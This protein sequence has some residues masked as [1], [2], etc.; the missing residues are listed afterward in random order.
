VPGDWQRIRCGTRAGQQRRV[1]GTCIPLITGIPEA[2]RDASW[3]VK[4][5]FYLAAVAEGGDGYFLDQIGDRRRSGG[6]V[7]AAVARAAE[8]AAP[9][10]GIP[11]NKTARR[12][13]Q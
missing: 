11:G 9:L 8:R 10:A 4:E 2:G 5:R 12:D 1:P 7:R 13:Q 3:R 6:P